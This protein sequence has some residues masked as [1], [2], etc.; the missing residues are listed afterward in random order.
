[1]MGNLDIRLTNRVRTPTHAV[2]W[3]F[4]SQPDT[5]AVKLSTYPLYPFTIFRILSFMSSKGI[6]STLGFAGPL[7]SGA[8]AL[9]SSITFS[10]LNRK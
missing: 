6:D 5:S 10:N 9:K 8:E 1:M 3:D 7:C 2:F 4:S